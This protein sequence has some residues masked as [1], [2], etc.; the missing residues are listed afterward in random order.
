VGLGLALWAFVQVALAAERKTDR[1]TATS[2][3]DYTP[4]SVY[5]VSDQRAFLVVERPRRRG[6]VL[7]TDDGGRTWAELPFGGDS[8]TDLGVWFVTPDVGYLVRGHFG[9]GG[10][11]LVSMLR[12]LDGGDQWER[13]PLPQP[14]VWYPYQL[15]FTS[16]TDVEIRWEADYRTED[17]M[18]S[19][20]IAERD[21]RQRPDE[22]DPRVIGR[23]HRDESWRLTCDEPEVECVVLRDS[24]AGRW[25]PAHVFRVDRSSS[26]LSFGAKL[27]RRIR[28]HNASRSAAT[29]VVLELLCLPTDRVTGHKMGD[30]FASYRRE[31]TTLAD[32]T[33]VHRVF[34]TFEVAEPG[35]AV[36]VFIDSDY[37]RLLEVNRQGDVWPLPRFLSIEAETEPEERL[38]ITASDEVAVVHRYEVQHMPYPHEPQISVGIR[39]LVLSTNRISSGGGRGCDVCVT[40]RAAE[41]GDS[42]AI[43]LVA[44]TMRGNNTDFWVRSR[45]RWR[46]DE[47]LAGAVERMQ[48][49]AVQGEHPEEGPLARYRMTSPYW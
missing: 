6:G 34:V 26:L 33:P 38:W 9:E 3:V 16:E 42:V 20:A 40:T 35:D 36:S 31:A 30:R 47:Q 17:G 25:Q 15:E 5:G 44:I 18:A 22:M 37:A 29:C 46:L 7:R 1:P 24:A 48:L 2:V 28:I 12:T 4:A 41:I 45:P 32:G 43:D 14:P 39:A 11:S 23:R 21:D 19:W 27:D 49:P 10:G 13:R 8:G